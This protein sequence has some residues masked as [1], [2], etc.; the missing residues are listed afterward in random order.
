MHTLVWT[1]KKVADRTM[2]YE[3]KTPDGKLV[4]LVINSHSK[5]Y[6]WDSFI[7]RAFKPMGTLHT[8]HRTLR[9]AKAYVETTYAA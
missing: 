1:G 3:A 9:E 5:W 8:D 2:E 6:P 4:A 7:E